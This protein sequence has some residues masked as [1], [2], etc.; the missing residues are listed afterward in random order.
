MTV[1]RLVLPEHVQG[2]ANACA[3]AWR[4][5]DHHP[6]SERLSR[7]HLRTMAELAD[8]LGVEAAVVRARVSEHRTRPYGGLLDRGVAVYRAV[9]EIL[10][11]AQPAAPTVSDVVID[12]CVDALAAPLDPKLQAVVDRARARAYGSG[13][14]GG[15]VASD[16]AVL[17]AGV[18][19]R[20]AGSA[21][22]SR[23]LPVPGDAPGA[24]GSPPPELAG[25]AARSTSP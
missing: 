13:G 25:S 1:E 4:R 3:T 8:V 24:T 20:A 12:E 6:R 14:R 21:S 17:G 7:E 19:P 18:A 10:G 16:T 5:W 9:A 11:L 23:V 2:P 22:A 15:D